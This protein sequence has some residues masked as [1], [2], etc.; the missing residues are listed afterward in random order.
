[1]GG[2]NFTETLHGKQ[3]LLTLILTPFTLVRFAPPPPSMPFL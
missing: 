1:M 2:G 3:L